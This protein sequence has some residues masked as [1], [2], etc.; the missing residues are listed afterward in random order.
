MN[1]KIVAEI[2]R[3]I[4]DVARKQRRTFDEENRILHIVGENLNAEPREVADM[5]TRQYGAN[6][7]GEAM[8]GIY[9]IRVLRRCDLTNITLRKEMY[10]RAEEMANGLILRAKGSRNMSITSEEVEAAYP[11]EKFKRMI[12]LYFINRFEAIA[13]SEEY[14]LAMRFNKSFMSE[15]LDSVIDILSMDTGEDELDEYKKELIS[16]ERR[17]NAANRTIEQL[18]DSF[19]AEVEEAKKEEHRM[20]LGKLNSRTY[21]YLLDMVANAQGGLKEL[22]YKGIDV[23]YELGSVPIIIKNLMRFVADAG[24]SPIMQI[25]QTLTICAA[26]AERFNYEGEPF[27]DENE[28]KTVMVV[29]SG[30]QSDDD[31]VI[32]NPRVRELNN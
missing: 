11:E 6:D 8:T 30:W 19:D 20:L 28:K 26:D 7:D 15:L 1:E 24:I 23:P 5:Y 27:K 13:G 14:T 25:G 32:S 9:V 16:L 12:A 10:K 2:K 17:L 4:R 29:A 3:A 31:I 18:Q 22:R 21:G